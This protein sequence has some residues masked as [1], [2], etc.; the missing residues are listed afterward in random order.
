MI[1]THSHLLP[2][3]DGVASFEESIETL[4]EYEKLGFK[5]IIITPHY[6]GGTKYSV[7]NSDKYKLFVELQN[8]IKENNIN[9]EI[10]LGNEIFLDENTFDDLKNGNC[11]TINS[12]K[13]ILI[14]IPRNDII[15]NFE[16]IIF[17]LQSKGLKV[18]IAHPERY[19][20]AK[21][22]YS[23]IEDWCNRG[24]LLQINFESILGK[25]GK[26]SQKLVKYI[27][28]NNYASIIGGD[29]HHKDSMFFKNFSKNKKKIIKIIGEDKFKELTEVIPNKIIN[30]E[31]I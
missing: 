9:I 24:I 20:I 25:Y 15:N 19:M 8:K 6:V 28:K 26:E 7:N 31:D 1:E 29:V 12:G 23:H 16:N 3:D 30:S 17:K 10:Y 22:D 14:E 5:K 18:I 21:N 27:L 11:C 2:I 4:K 13:Y